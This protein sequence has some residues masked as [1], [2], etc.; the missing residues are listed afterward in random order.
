MVTAVKGLLH[1]R[2]PLLLCECCRVVCC[3]MRMESSGV[4]VTSKGD[5]SGGPLTSL[6]SSFITGYYPNWPMYI[7]K[8]AQQ[9]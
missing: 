3:A 8:V 7:S 1:G 6:I 4:L 9:Q 5:F 2:L